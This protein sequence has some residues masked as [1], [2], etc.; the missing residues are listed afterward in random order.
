MIVSSAGRMLSPPSSSGKLSLL[1]KPSVSDVKPSSA[2][3]F[4]TSS[5]ASASVKFS[6]DSLSSASARPSSAVQPS[7][8]V[9][10]CALTLSTVAGSTEDTVRSAAISQA[11]FLFIT[12]F[13]LHKIFSII[14]LKFI[15]KQ[16]CI[17]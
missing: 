15:K 4:P 12:N 10:S 13:L 8:S 17:L 7:A 11:I 6:A 14:L 5:V 2:T 16:T 9:T 3:M 1:T